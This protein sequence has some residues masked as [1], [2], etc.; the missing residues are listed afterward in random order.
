M[1]LG[2]KSENEIKKLICPVSRKESKVKVRCVAS[3][4]PLWVPAGY[5]IVLSPYRLIS[6]GYCRYGRG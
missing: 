3:R 2:L 5:R 1:L 6:E 4:C